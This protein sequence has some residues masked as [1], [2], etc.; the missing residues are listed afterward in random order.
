M[1]NDMKIGYLKSSTLIVLAGIL[2]F[3]QLQAGQTGAG[4]ILVPHKS[5]PCGMPEGIP[6]PVQGVLVFEADMKLDQI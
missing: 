3:C 1:G 4:K 5:W 2:L 6:V